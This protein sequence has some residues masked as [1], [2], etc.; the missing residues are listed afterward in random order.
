MSNYL[1]AMQQ[2]GDPNS[3]LQLA[4]MTMGPSYGTPWQHGLIT[5][6]NLRNAPLPPPRP[7]NYNYPMPDRSPGPGFEETAPGY[8]EYMPSRQ[9]PPP[10]GTPEGQIQPHTMEP[11][12]Y[13][14]DPINKPPPQM[15]EDETEQKGYNSPQA[16]PQT[17]REFWNRSAL[18]WPFAN[19]GEDI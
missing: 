14:T 13:G 17:S 6:P 16:N 11:G 3:L 4:A 7:P 1:Q 12:T 15:P 10:P 2:G 18:K 8:W 9:P 5:P 19:W